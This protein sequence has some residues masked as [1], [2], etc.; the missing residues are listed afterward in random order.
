MKKTL[1]LLITIFTF[2]LSVFAVQDLRWRNQPIK[3]YM[4]NIG[5][6]SSWMNQAFKTWEQQSKGLVQFK[7]VQSKQFSDIDVEFVDIVENCNDINAVGCTHMYSRDGRNFS[8]AVITIGVMNYT[9]SKNKGKVAKTGS[10]RNKENIYGVMLHEIG[11]AIG[12][13]HSKI[14]KSIMYPYD[15]EMIQVLTPNDLNILYKKYSH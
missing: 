14:P 13:D 15:L 12:L 6:M 8:K 10:L 9:Y 5:Q 3:V 2:C 1:L 4:P 11:H 7:F